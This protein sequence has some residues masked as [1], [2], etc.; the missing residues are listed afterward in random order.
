M[1]AAS[2][3]IQARDTRR[4][5]LKRTAMAGAASKVVS[6]ICNLVMV[7]VLLRS[8]GEAPFGMWATYQSLQMLLP[9]A[10]FGIGN[11]MMNAI[12]AAAAHDDEKGIQRLVSTGAVL[13]LAISLIGGGVAAVG[14]PFLAAWLGTGSVDATADLRQGLAIFVVGGLAAI[15]LSCADRLAAAMQAGYVPH[16]VRALVAIASLIAVLIAARIQAGFPAF[17]LATVGPPLFAPLLTWW[18]L[19]RRM[20]HVVPRLQALAW[21]TIPGIARTGLA[22]LSVQFAMIFGF[23]LDLLFVEK[24][25]GATKAAEFAIVQRFF[26]VV[27]VVA[28][29][30][31]QPLWPA[32]ADARARSDF[33]WI[34][35][36]FRT[37]MTRTVL[38]SAALLGAMVA[39][40]P[41]IIPIWVGEDRSPAASLV[42]LYAFW[43]AAYVVGM[44]LAMLWNGMHW[45][46][47]QA[48]LGLLFAAGSVMLKVFKVSTGGAESLVTINIVCYGLIVLIPGLLMF[49]SWLNSVR[50]VSTDN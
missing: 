15:P 33:A 37:S 26:S 47:L 7:P 25:A 43:T 42:T 36:T 17:C 14:W 18:W 49:V 11:G 5:M 31:L 23:G 40:S 30:A 6:A 24:L 9:F 12:T 35:G 44:A 13:L 21:E 2:E 8:M 41:W 27:P 10:D 22:F 34:V 48:T 20:P 46:R 39:L 16:V 29:I 19:S 38:F 32:Y 50:K 45:L 28:A 1:I 3:H 4:Q